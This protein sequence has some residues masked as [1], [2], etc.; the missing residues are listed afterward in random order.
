MTMRTDM[1]AFGAVA[2]IGA[3]RFAARGFVVIDP[4]GTF[5]PPTTGR[6]AG[7]TL[8]GTPTRRPRLE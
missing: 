6:T 7:T 1:H 5:V 8:A 3:G 4:A 2:P